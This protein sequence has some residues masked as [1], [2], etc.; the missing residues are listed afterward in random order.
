M[1][2]LENFFENPFENQNIGLDGLMRFGN[3]HL[4]RL[5]AKPVSGLAALIA[6]TQAALAAVSTGL[7]ADESQLGAR[8]G[9]NLAKN[10]FRTTL[11]A[12]M[13]KIALKVQTQFGETSP[14][15]TTCFPHGRTVFSQCSDDKLEAE[16]TSVVTGVT[17]YQTQLGTQTVT[18]ATALK[19]GWATVWSPAKTAKGN[20]SASQDIK[21]SARI[22]LER[23]L[24]TNLLALASLFQG[25]RICWQFI[26]NKACSRR[27][28]AVPL[29]P[30][31]R[32]RLRLRPAAWPRPCWTLIPAMTPTS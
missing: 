23:Q 26:C 29:P 9:A 8:K 20:K 19:N 25:Q 3:D 14:E 30:H 6:P 21:N 10:S 31:R 32:R 4:G 7:G 18:D 1:K 24:H 13:G 11:P 5:I 12:A 22:V 2:N 27:T 28:R 16:L 17:A 15:F